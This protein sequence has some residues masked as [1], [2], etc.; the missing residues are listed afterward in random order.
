[1][2]DYMVSIL[3][4]LEQMSALFQIL[5][6]IIYN[7]ENLPKWGLQEFNLTMSFSASGT[8]F[9]A[10]RLCTESERSMTNRPGNHQA[11]HI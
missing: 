3:Y 9:L 8:L 2:I 6:A 5:A 4:V 11:H 10:V 7:E 1:M